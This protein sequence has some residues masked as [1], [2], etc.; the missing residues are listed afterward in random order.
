MPWTFPA[1]HHLASAAADSAAVDLG[2]VF[3]ATSARLGPMYQKL[4]EHL[5][6]PD[7]MG[8]MGPSMYS[9]GV[10]TSAST[11]HGSLLCTAAGVATSPKSTAGA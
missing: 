9:R 2:L 10:L 3:Y 1:C 6:E 7:W 11:G 8:C 4:A 5:F